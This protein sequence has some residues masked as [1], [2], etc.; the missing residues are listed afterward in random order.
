MYDIIVF[1][2]LPKFDGTHDRRSRI[3]LVYVKE[4][5]SYRWSRIYWIEHV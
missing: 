4:N 3:F 5:F 1:T 2:L